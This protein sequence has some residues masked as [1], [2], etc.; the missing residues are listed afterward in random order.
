MCV[1][2]LARNIFN[3]VHTVGIIELTITFLIK[4]AK[5]NRCY[6]F[7]LQYLLKHK[8]G[9]VILFFDYSS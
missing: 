4:R 7:T 5:Y 8:N 3:G 2:P 6:D 1:N 9:Y